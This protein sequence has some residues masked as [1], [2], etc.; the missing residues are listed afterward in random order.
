M[1]SVDVNPGDDSASITFGG[2]NSDLNLTEKNFTWLALPGFYSF[3]FHTVRSGSLTYSLNF[4]GSRKTYSVDI[5]FVSAN[6]FDVDKR[7][8]RFLVKV[9]S[10]A[11]E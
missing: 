6:R 11:L 4:L 8:F 3:A 9:I 5:D 10:E 1:F 2:W 7:L